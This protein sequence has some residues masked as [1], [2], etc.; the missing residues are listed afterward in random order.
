RA[1]PAVSEKIVLRGRALFEEL[2]KEGAKDPEI[3]RELAWQYLNLGFLYMYPDPE[4]SLKDFSTAIEPFA[5]LAQEDP[6]NAVYRREHAATLATASEVLQALNRTKEA[7]EYCKRAITLQQQVVDGDA[8]NASFQVDLVEFQSVLA[9][10]LM[11]TG[12]RQEG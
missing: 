6:S 4:R 8:R 12:S 10:L 7:I 5:S 11:G 2:L 9:S 3:R 1:Q